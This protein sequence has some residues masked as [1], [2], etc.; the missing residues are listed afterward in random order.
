[1]K[2][3]AKITIIH[4]TAAAGGGSICLRPEDNYTIR[5]ITDGMAITK[6]PPT[7]TITEYMIPMSNVKYIQTE[8]V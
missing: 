2:T 6:K 7:E 3:I 5:E 8:T 4:F 1:M